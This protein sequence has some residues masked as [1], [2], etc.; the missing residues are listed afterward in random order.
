MPIP[1]VSKGSSLDDSFFI[2]KV[3]SLSTNWLI[4]VN[5]RPSEPDFSPMAMECETRLGMI[6]LCLSNGPEMGS[7]LET[8]SF[9]SL[10]TSLMASFGVPSLITLS[11]SSMG[12]LFWMSI[13][14]VFRNLSIS[15]C[16]IIFPINGMNKSIKSN[17]LLY[18]FCFFKI[19]NN[20]VRLPMIV[21]NMILCLMTMSD[22]IN[23]DLVIVGS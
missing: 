5:V 11:A 7:P 6:L 8:S 16:R 19:L 13:S 1:M 18:F 14:N 23:K 21:P 2:V 10:T 22:I 15:A 20:T 9:I 3:S 4:L 12:T 17:F